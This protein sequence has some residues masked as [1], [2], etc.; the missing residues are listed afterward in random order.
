MIDSGTDSGADSRRTI[1]LLAVAQALY[2]SCAITV[3]ATEGLVGLEIAPTP[4]YATL[5]ITTFVLGAMF[6]TVPFPSAR[7]TLR[8]PN[9]CGL[10]T[11]PP[12][13]GQ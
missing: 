1:L 5:P 12:A 6:T 9:R 3:F 7:A 8:S 13:T 10:R 2:S 4:G 11:T